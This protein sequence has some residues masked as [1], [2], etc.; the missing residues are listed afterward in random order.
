MHNIRNRAVSQ[1]LAIVAGLLFSVVRVDAQEV[2][3]R[4]DT[5]VHA[6]FFYSPTCPHCE[7]VIREHLLP[8][9]DRYGPSLV[10][11]ALSTATEYGSRLFRAAMERDDVPEDEWGVPFLIVGDQRMTG[12]L[13]I[14]E[15]L[16]RLVD[17]G[18]ASGGIDLPD[19]PELISF[20]DAQGA[21]RVIEPGPR[22]LVRDPAPDQTTSEPPVDA[23]TDV[24]PTEMTPLERFGQDRAGN[25]LAVIVLVSMI[26]A[27]FRSFTPTKRRSA[28]WPEWVTPALSALG[29]A[30]A[31]YLSYVEVSGNPATCGPVGDCNTVQQSPHATLFGVLPVGVLGVAAYAG[32]LV[33]WM[34]RTLGSDRLRT[35]AAL[36]LWMA[37]LGG[38]LFSVYL[39]FL[40]PFVIGAT[41]LWCL[42]SAVVMTLLM[43]ASVAP[44]SAILRHHAS[45]T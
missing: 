43:M 26:F 45:S 1:G 24:I 34:G 18:L 41:C 11:V 19:F 17:A 39:T 16:P 20:L 13:E 8:L 4:P 32:I 36:G 40:E 7:R 2:M 15:R 3:P 9:Q 30:V 5:V 29:L 35:S 10:V 27:L 14:P 21:L 44:V 12:G 37:T 6:V 33:L 23:G 38:T 28:E 22:Y 31:V 42:T 25:A